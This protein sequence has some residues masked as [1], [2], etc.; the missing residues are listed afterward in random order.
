MPPGSARPRGARHVHAIAVDVALLEDYVADVDADAELDSPS[1]G[2]AASRSAMPFWIATAHDRIDRARELDQRAV[3]GE[4]D[5]A[6]ACSAIRS[7]ITPYD[8]LKASVRAGLVR[9]SAG[10]SPPR[11]RPV[12]PQAYVPC[13]GPWAHLHPRRH[14]RQQQLSY[15]ELTCLSIRSL[16]LLPSRLGRATRTM[17]MLPRGVRRTA[18]RDLNDPHRRF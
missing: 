13:A 16:V 17:P 18:A 8:G 2:S 14:N 11:P 9:P 7:S 3:A 4:L 6:A 12:S 1:S 10:C 15:P 5:H